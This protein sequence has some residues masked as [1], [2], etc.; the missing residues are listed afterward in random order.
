MNEWKDKT[1]ETEEVVLKENKPAFQYLIKLWKYVFTSAPKMCLIFMGLSILLSLLRPVLAFIWGRYVDSANNY[2]NGSNISSVILLAFL[3][4]VI[5][6]LA[7]L[8]NRYI[9]SQELIE[10]LDVVQA[11]RFQESLN[12][13]IYRKLGSISAEYNEIPK[14]NDL[15]SRVFGFVEDGWKGLNGSVM[16]PSYIMLAKLIS[17][18][19]IAA[20]LYIINP[21]LCLILIAAPIPTL[22][23]TYIGNKLQ[24]LFIKDN[25]KLK[26]EADYFQGLM[27]GSAVKEI[28]VMTLFDFFYEKWKTRIDE[29]TIREN[30]SYLKKMCLDTFS[31]VITGSAS[32]AGSI[33]AI[34]MMTKGYISLGALSA[35][36]TLI[37]T[38]INDTSVF[39]TSLAAFMSKKNEAAMFFDLIDLPEETREGILVEGIGEVSFEDVSY[40][41]PLTDKY[42]LS[43]INITI[44]KGEKVALVGENGAGKTTFVKLISGIVQ[45]SGGKLKI[46]GLDT[47]KAEPQSRYASAGSVSQETAKYQTFSV[48]DNVYIGDSSKKRNEDDIK[49]SLAF[50][51]LNCF[52]GSEILG[53]E[54]GGTDLSG[55][56][57][58]KLAI[59]RCCYRNHDFIILDEPTGNLDPLAE[60]EILT[61][62]MRMAENKTV[63]MV[64]HRISAASLADRIIVFEKGKIKEDGTHQELLNAGG[65]YAKLY[66]TQAKWYKR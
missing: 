41:Y 34:V 7:D 22:Y 39:F 40:R 1:A 9:Y 56:E 23:T 51:G 36:M 44:H 19:S 32:V 45:P 55:G 35:V 14:I 17:V 46:N 54:I 37:N 29:Y 25:A 13:R 11:N 61:K 65:E 64:T 59:A 28:K 5:N 2:I 30:K 31:N 38:L 27:L 12:S 52:D 43:H 21:W 49:E 47:D 62:Y 42:V 63:I 10:R 24:F 50:A 8:L 58:Q 3:Y 57:W 26:R 33:M 20:S 53:K 15:T 16:T 60:S 6:F 4:Y 18:I 48:S 66:Q